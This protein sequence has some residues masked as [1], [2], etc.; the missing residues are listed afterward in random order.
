MNPHGILILGHGTPSDEGTQAFLEFVLLVEEMAGETPVS[1]GFLDF[2]SP[3]IM[4]G[5]SA[6]AHCG[7]LRMS[8]VPVFLSAAGHTANDLPQSIALVKKVFRPLQIHL[9]PHVGSQPK[10]AEL[11]ALRYQEAIAGRVEVPAEE[12]LLV[13][14]SHG[15]PEPEALLE[16]EKFALARQILTPVARI[17]PCFSQMG[18]P[19][20][21]DMLPTLVKPIFRRIVVQP[22]FL[23]KGRLVDAIAYTTAAVATQHPEIEWIVAEP[24]GCHR[25]LAEAVLE[26]GQNGE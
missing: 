22:H 18:V 8:A 2:A 19:L 23:L 5:A 10:V 3:T 7:V 14:A 25:L 4:E 12:T 24:L 15:S 1:V 13:I 20:L 6:L 9:T 11:S 26:L 16:L 17:V 21:K